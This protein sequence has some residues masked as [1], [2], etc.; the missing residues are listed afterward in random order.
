MLVLLGHEDKAPLAISTKS[1]DLEGGPRQMMAQ[2]ILS[3]S[4]SH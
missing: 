2:L 1:A 3:N 4:L